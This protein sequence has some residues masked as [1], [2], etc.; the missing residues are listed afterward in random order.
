MTPWSYKVK[1]LKKIPSITFEE[2]AVKFVI[3]PGESRHMA[4]YHLYLPAKKRIPPSYHKIAHEVIF[5]L[6][7]CGRVHLNK[8]VRPVK[9]GDAILVRPRTWHSFST[10]RSSMTMLAVTAPYV[11]SKIDLYHR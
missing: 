7:G 11:D 1:T 6:S 5:I 10:G 2:M 4:C 9:S 3:N 8:T